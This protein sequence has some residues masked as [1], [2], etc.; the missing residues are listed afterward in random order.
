VFCSSA[1]QEYP[2]KYLLPIAL[3]AV[4]IVAADKPADRPGT[5]QPADK[6]VGDKPAEKKT[7]K[8]LIQ[9]T[10]MFSAFEFDDIVFTDG[11]LKSSIVAQLRELRATVK[12]DG[13]SSSTAAL[14]PGQTLMLALDPAEKPPTLDL[15][16]VKGGKNVEEK[17]MLLYELRGDTLRLCWAGSSREERPKAFTSKGGQYILTLKREEKK[18]EK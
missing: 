16:V 5:D 9:G 10:W 12:D 2:V 13:V 14:L 3:L 1:S 7:D 18:P 6:P 11:D 17:I 15:Q 4:A 8:D